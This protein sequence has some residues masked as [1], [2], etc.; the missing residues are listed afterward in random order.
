MNQLLSSTAP[1]YISKLNFPR[2]DV[3]KY[4][5]ENLFSLT[6]TQKQTKTCI[7]MDVHYYKLNT[8]GIPAVTKLLK[9]KLPS[10]L[11]TTCYNDLGLPFR[12]EVRNT[13]IGHLF[14]HILLEYLCQYKIAK[15][16]R[17]ATYT[18]KTNWDWTRDPMG[19]FYI[20]LS[21]GKRE[22]DIFH[23]ALMQTVSLMK[24]ILQYKKPFFISNTAPVSNGLKNGERR[25]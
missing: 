21:C 11:R 13:E 10:V 7:I 18:G 5:A 24:I 9:K 17:R 25:W 14:E 2:P 16:A 8:E 1:A 22:R 15:G 19:K 23:P 20:T 6:I 4:F 12:E 3:Q